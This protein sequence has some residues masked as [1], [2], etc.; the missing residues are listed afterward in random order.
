LDN[1][2]RG[3]PVPPPAMAGS[4]QSAVPPNHASVLSRPSISSPASVHDQI[5]SEDEDREV[6]EL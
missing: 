6:F 1:I 5:T 4:L 2:G 3:K